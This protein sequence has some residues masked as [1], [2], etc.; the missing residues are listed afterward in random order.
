M[1]AEA[2]NAS[3]VIAA[4]RGGDLTDAVYARLFAEHPDMEAL[5][6]RDTTGAVKGEMLAKVFEMILDLVGRGGYA[7]HLVQCEVVTHDAYGVPPDVFPAFFDVV[8]EVVKHTAGAQWTPAMGAA[9]GE[10]LSKLRWYATHPDQS[11]A[12]G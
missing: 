9:W 7:G 4:E 6:V 10:V 8:A 3:L 5:F 11:A 2:I 12:V 1:D